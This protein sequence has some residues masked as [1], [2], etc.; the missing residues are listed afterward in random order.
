MRSVSL[1]TQSHPF[2]LQAEDELQKLRGCV[3]TSSSLTYQMILDALHTIRN[4]YESINEVL[5]ISS[6]QNGLSYSQQRNLID[7]EL[8]ESINLLDICSTSRYNMGKIKTHIQDLESALRRRGSEAVKGKTRDYVYLVN[9]ASKDL[10]NQTSSKTESKE[11]TATVLALLRDARE[12]TISLLQSLFAFLSKQIIGQKT[13][14]WSIVSTL[15]KRRVACKE[16]SFDIA[17][18]KE[19]VEGLENELECLFRHMIQCRV[20]LLNI[21]SL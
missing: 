1:P 6:N 9:K 3:A 16:N 8:D 10:K 2:I 21:C 17:T 13:S 20:S 14:K 5:Y 4:L 18:L 19:N 7:Q 12:I 15:Q 11:G